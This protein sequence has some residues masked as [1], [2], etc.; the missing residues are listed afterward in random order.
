MSGHSKGEWKK[1]WSDLRNRWTI[2][3]GDKWIATIG[4]STIE[5]PEESEANADLIAAVPDLLEACLEYIREME[6]V[7]SVSGA[8][9]EKIFGALAKIAGVE[10]F[11]RVDGCAYK[12]VL[13][14]FAKAEPEVKS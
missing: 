10:E 8:T 5:T 4:Q 1:V 14:H 11:G 9:E 13:E 7:Y 6:E 3:C 12:A 2:M